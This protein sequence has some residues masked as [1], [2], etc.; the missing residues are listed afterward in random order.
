GGSAAIPR[1]EDI[2]GAWPDVRVNVDVKDWPAIGPLVETVRRTG[3]LDRICVASFSDRRL[4]RVRAALGPALCTS[5][6]PLGV[7]RLRVTSYGRLLG[8]AAASGVPCAQLP[9]RAG[10]VPIVDRRLV[11]AAHRRGLSVHVWT[12]DDP[13][14][15]QR[16]LD[17]G[18]DG[19]MT[20]RPEV[21]REV[22]LG[23][24]LWHGP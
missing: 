5:L 14:E 11:D 24:G 6:G 8:R 17:L 15:M 22:L 3:A 20:D 16:L 23:R 1:L 21:L 4:A 13:A 19:I 12:V 2:L 10:P 9:V 7:L 18:V